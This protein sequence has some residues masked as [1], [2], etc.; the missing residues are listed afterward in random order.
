MDVQHGA[1]EPLSLTEL[2]DRLRPY[3]HGLVL[4][5]PDGPTESLV[6]AGELVALPDAVAAATERLGSRVDR[7]VS[8]SDG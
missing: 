5:D 6:H 1:D 4:H 3:S 2:L 8:G 7:V